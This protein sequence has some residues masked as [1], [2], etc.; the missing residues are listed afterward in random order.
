MRVECPYSYENFIES[1]GSQCPFQ[2]MIEK[3]NWMERQSYLTQAKLRPKHARWQEFLAEFD[4]EIL[5]N[6]RKKNVVAN[7][8]S[9]GLVSCSGR[10]SLG[11]AGGND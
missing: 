8:K 3:E 9:K 10:G 4:F 11:L 7:E 2:N 1:I 6:P 5:Y